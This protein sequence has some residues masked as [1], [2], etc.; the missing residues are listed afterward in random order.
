MSEQP[1]GRWH[2]RHSAKDVLRHEVWSR[3][4]DSGAAVGSPWSAI[5][6]FRGA[7]QAA[8]QL[9]RHPAWESA[10]VVKS[11]PDAAQSWVRL[12]ALEQGKRVYT[13]VPEL[14]KD[15]P[16]IL[17]D[18]VDLRARGIPFEDVMYSAGAVRHG[19]RVE[20]ADIEPLDFVVVGCVAVTRAGGRTGKGAGFADLELG[21]FRHYGI[22]APETP[23][24]TTVH[25]IQLVAD[26]RIVMEAHDT[27]LDWI[28]TPDQLIATDTA[29]PDPGPI[30]WE[31]L[32]PDQFRDIPFLEGLKRALTEP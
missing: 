28:A 22:V 6:D 2:G 30:D 9:S 17:L 29:Y 19:L 13:P 26:E 14:V 23:I 4:E 16:F 11:N 15:F 27:P 7:E 32:Q 18:P 1:R 12:K 24:A 21:L 25:D 8:Q 10:G 31:R 20:F 5:P 3:L